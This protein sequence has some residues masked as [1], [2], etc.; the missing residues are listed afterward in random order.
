MKAGG[1]LPAYQPGMALAH[2]Q[3]AGLTFKQTG[4]EIVLQTCPFCGRSDW[5]LY[6]SNATGQ[7]LCHHAKCAEKGG[8]YRFLKGTGAMPSRVKPLA[9]QDKPVATKRYPLEQFAPHE[10]ALANDPEALAYLASRGLTLETAQAWHFGVKTEAGVKWLMMP[11]V[12]MSGDIC[13]VKYRSLPPTP[14]RFKRMGGGESI[15]YGEQWFNE[16]HEPPGVLYLCEGE[17]DAVT[18]WQQGFRPVVSTTT[19]AGSFK[20]RWHDLILQLNPEVIV[21]CY[22]SDVAGQDGAKHLIRKFDD[23][24][25][26]NV[27]LPDAKDA[28]EY[29]LDHTKVE[30]DQLLDETHPAE[31]E[32]VRSMASVLD[33]LEEQLFL[34]AEGCDGYPSQFAELN[35]LIAGGFWKGTVTTI[36]GTAGSG[37]TS[38]VLQ[39]L[40][41]QADQDNPS[42][43]LC[44]EMPEV[45]M[46]RKIIEHRYH[47]PMQKITLADVQ[48]HRADLERLPFYFGYKGGSWDEIEQAIRTA[49]KRYDLRLFALDNVNFLV[50]DPKN[51]THEISFVTKRLKELAVEL[52][53]AVFLIAQ[54]GKFDDTSRL[55][56]MNDI[57]EASA[58]GQDADNVLLLWRQRRV[59]HLKNGNLQLNET[60]TSYSPLAVLRVD[61]ARYS[62]GGEIALY[63]D[64]AVSTYRELTEEERATLDITKKDRL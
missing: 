9:L 21:L 52:Q 53:L 30:F 14:K 60:A 18:L 63:F 61:K 7:F 58:I 25:V 57:K 39:F 59:S 16:L 23:R 43:L 19:G 4:D 24:K 11:Y 48:R 33:M 17:L 5:R 22:D 28:N 32:R 41:H 42:Y 15:L 45:M 46:L 36:S 6:I 38:L 27:V 47:I 13:D 64:G 50:R 20:P 55:I 35:A 54:P 62:S 40:M 8:W 2:V 34:G 37:K 26:L 10:A 49:I 12:S 29:F 31:L 56:T 51:V 44:L 3:Q 1:G